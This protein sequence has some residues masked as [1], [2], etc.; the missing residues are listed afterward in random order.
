MNAPQTMF[1]KI[2]ARHAIVTRED[3]N[4]L[5][6]IDRLLVQENVFHA[7]DKLRSE[8]RSV[9]RPDQVFA[10][11]DHYVPTKDRAA[12]IPDPEI[13]NMVS[14][15]ETNTREHDITLFGLGDVRQGILHVVGPEQG[16]TLPGI[17]L[18]GADSHT[19]THGAF[20][21]FAFGI[22]ASDVTHIL[23][24][25]TLWRKR[26][27]TMRVTMTGTPGFGVTPKDLVLGMIGRLGAGGGTGHVIEYAGPT[28]RALS[29]EGRMTVCNMSI[30][31]GARAGLVSPD[32]KTY[33]YVEGRPYA[34]KGPDFARA[35][36]NWR[37]LPT[38]DGAPFD[39]E[40]ELDAAAIAPLVT[41]GT[42]PE[43][44]APITE[45]IPDPATEP[46]LGRRE[47]VVKALDYMALQP[48]TPLDGIEVDR[49]FIGSCTN[50][51]LE[52]L[53]AAA[54]VAKGRRA[55][56]PTMVVPGSGLVKRDAEAEGLDRVFIDAG[57]E[58]R[59]AGCSMCVATNGDMLQ[60]GERCASTSNRNFE[61]RQGR[62]GRTHLV[63]PAM[64]AAAA[65]TGH[66][67]DVRRLMKDI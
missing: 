21:A 17:V 16:I 3:G 61:G 25:Q 29:M 55:M 30:E 32:E 11:T 10:F 65:V 28:I 47:R 60:P 23:A 40:I 33:S 6:A 56:V 42:S 7:F 64:A 14:M 19:S 18:A 46:D 48:G 12:G 1:D 58:W 52:D 67:T 26:P 63:S 15:M 62:G 36:A 66:L 51:R 59:D 41:W 2:W 31:A 53:R 34:P 50:G 13:R 37:A 57:F 27:K 8:G 49:V 20:G 24:T 39:R 38:D 43:D 9:R 5:L 54:S 4:T 35:V 45:S 22:G 44:V